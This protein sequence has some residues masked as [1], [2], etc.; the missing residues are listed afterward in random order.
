MSF[1]TQLKHQYEKIK[2][3]EQ[4]KRNVSNSLGA[5]CSTETVVFY[6]Y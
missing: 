5:Y 3:M 6:I 1:Y 2:K 4:L